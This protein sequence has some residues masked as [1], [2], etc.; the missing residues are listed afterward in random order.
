M[1]SICI[2]SDISKDSVSDGKKL[3]RVGARE[4]ARALRELTASAEDLGS[5]PSI[6]MVAHRICLPPPY[7]Q[8][9][10]ACTY[11]YIQAKIP[12]HIK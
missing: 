1:H 10:Q 5:V 2:V 7:F 9:H 8:G 4:T 3:G 11:I 6:H 12:I